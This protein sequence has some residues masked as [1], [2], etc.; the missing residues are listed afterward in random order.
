MAHRQTQHGVAK[1]GLGQE[2][3]EEARGDKPRTYRIAFPAKAGPRPCPVKGCSG[4]ASTW[5]VMRM[6]F[7]H[8]NV[9]DTAVILEEG[10]LPRLWCP[11]CEIMMMWRSL[12]GM[13]RHTAQCKRGA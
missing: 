6:H 7:W 3:K 5:T 13:H 1:A 12:N 4:R 9:R 8:R 2:G 11:L 10:N